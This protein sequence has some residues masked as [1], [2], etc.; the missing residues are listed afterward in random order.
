MLQ[1]SSQYDGY[2]N[3]RFP[4]KG[5]VTAVSLY[6]TLYSYLPVFPSNPPKNQPNQNGIQHKIPLPLSYVN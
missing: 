3:T 5:P 2:I 6:Y 1:R 4:Q